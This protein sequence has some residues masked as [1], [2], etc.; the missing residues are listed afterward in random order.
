[1]IK[2]LATILAA[3]AAGLPC[4]KG[5]LHA[6]TSVVQ[7]PIAGPA[8]MVAVCYANGDVLIGFAVD[9]ASGLWRPLPAIRIVSDNGS[10]RNV[11]AHLVKPGDATALFCTT[12]AHMRMKQKRPTEFN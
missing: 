4:L 2:L 8:R 5:T 10:G 9:A 12:P 11:D 3:A 7:A 1:M 6:Q